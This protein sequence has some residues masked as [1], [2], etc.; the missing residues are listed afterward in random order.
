V[1]AHGH[2]LRV[3]TAVF[4]RQEPRLGAQLLLDAGSLCVLEYERER[5]AIRV[6]NRPAASRD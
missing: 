5:P 4:L 6:W 1:V 3:L 2:F